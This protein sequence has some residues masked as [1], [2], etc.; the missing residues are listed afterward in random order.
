ML[1]PLSLRKVSEEM[2]FELRPNCKKQLAMHRDFRCSSGIGRILK[3]G[4]SAMCAPSTQ[5]KS[6]WWTGRGGRAGLERP[7]GASLCRTLRAEARGSVWLRV[8]EKP[9]ER[10]R[11]E[12]DLS[13]FSSEVITLLNHGRLKDKIKELRRSYCSGRK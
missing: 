9:L 8:L 4:N 6:T 1:C 12:N 7:A 13:Q 2:T 5:R 3:V 11:L 10:D